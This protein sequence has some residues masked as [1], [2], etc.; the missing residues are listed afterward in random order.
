MNIRLGPIEEKILRDVYKA[1]VLV[2]DDPKLVQSWWGLDWRTY[3]K[4]AEGLVKEGFLID[5][6][7][8]RFGTKKTSAYRALRLTIPQGRTYC[9]HH[10]L[11]DF[12]P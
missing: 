5:V 6:T 2:I 3:Q 11:I 9:E 1:E 10:K 12:M 8:E 7:E 4:M